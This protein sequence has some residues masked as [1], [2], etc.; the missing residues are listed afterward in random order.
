MRVHL[1]GVLAKWMYDC[2]HCKLYVHHT[3]SL[4]YTV[5]ENAGSEMEE[6]SAIRH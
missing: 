2:A 1:L 5:H 6:L 4:R 3:G